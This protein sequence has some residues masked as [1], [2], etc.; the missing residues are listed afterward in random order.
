MIYSKKSPDKLAG[1]GAKAIKKRKQEVTDWIRYSL[2]PPFAYYV[3]TDRPACRLRA[4]K[5]EY[6]SARRR[7]RERARQ[8]RA[9]RA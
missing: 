4:A 8:E 9:L 1:K 2:D 6:R 3:C 5:R 7:E